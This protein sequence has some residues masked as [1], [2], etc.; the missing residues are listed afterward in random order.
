[1]NVSGFQTFNDFSLGLDLSSTE[2]MLDPRALTIAQNVELTPQKGLSKRGGI[3]KLIATSPDEGKSIQ[4]VYNFYSSNGNYV[5]A[6][7]R[8]VDD[9]THLITTNLWAYDGT[10]WIQLT[11]NYSK[12]KM[13]F[14]T[15]KGFCY[16]ANGNDYNIKI[17]DVD[18]E[19]NVYSV[20][21]TPSENAPTLTEGG[22]GNLTGKYAYVY[23]YLSYNFNIRSNPSKISEIIDVSGKKIKVSV[24]ASDDPQVDKIEIYRTFA[25]NT[26]E[27]PTDFYLVATIDNKTTDYEDNVADASLG[28]LA[29]WDNFVPPDAKYL[30]MYLDRVF[31][32]NCPS[33]TNG[34]SLVVYSKIGNG[35]AVPA[36]NYEYFDRGDGEEITGITALQDVLIV[37][38]ESKFYTI[39]GDFELKRLTTSKY[40]VGNIGKIITLEDKVIFLSKNGWY[41]F[42]GTD[43]IPIS[44]TVAPK[45]IEQGYIKEGNKDCWSGVYYPLKNQ[46][47]FLINIPNLAPKIFVG[48]L[49]VP[50]L[51]LNQ[52]ISLFNMPVYVGWTEFVYPNHNLTCL[53]EY[54]N[55]DDGTTKII[56]G[57]SDGFIY[58]LDSESSD[59]GKPIPFIIQ[60]GWFSFTNVRSTYSLAI[61]IYLLRYAEINY[62]V[63]GQGDINIYFGVNYLSNE[64]SYHLADTIPL[65]CWPE[66]SENVVYCGED[67][68]CGGEAKFLL[69][70]ALSAGLTGG[71]FRFRIAGESSSKFIL[72]GINLFY[73]KKGVRLY[74]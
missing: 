23:V 64:L 8:T 35:D 27:I 25:L 66:D 72:N 11:T 24:A 17:S 6:N 50:F 31:Y 3:T 69:R 10:E 39:Y 7:V 21:I 30:T 42:D 15:H 63:D 13:S 18:G 56:A 74:R 36:E 19:L 68:Y 22:S 38:K 54:K 71:L 70:Q 60:S 44:K 51:N 53:A 20:G 14:L 33:E 48:T 34:E 41:S 37:F 40:D 32:A 43:L 29:E 2:N 52:P 49:L 67:T 46:L 57:S 47:Y 58:L 4:D 45:L 5:L 28:M 59:D 62:Y 16:C 61:L 1:M 9:I 26:G 12:N 73:R 65:Y 55:T